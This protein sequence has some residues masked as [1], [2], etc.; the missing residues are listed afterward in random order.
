MKRKEQHAVP[1]EYADR[2][3][4]VGGLNRYGRPNFL[5]VWGQSWT[6]RRG[7]IWN[8]DDGTYFRGYRDVVEDG[9]PCWVLK[10]WKAPEIYG[11]PALWFME[12]RDAAS[13]LQILGDFPWHGNYETVQP[14]VWK[15]LVNGRLVV[16]AMPLNSMIIDMVVPI[17]MKCKDATMTQ[18]KLAFEEMEARKNRDEVR[19]IEARKHDAKMAFGGNAVSFTRQGC[20][21][22]LINQ[23]MAAIEK[24]WAQGMTQL[25]RQGLG[26][27]FTR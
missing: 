3:T 13:G 10:E 15:G 14:F 22:P 25:K 24:N 8:H 9:R 20:R 17:I 21:T 11:S 16:E 18:K 27:S 23:K 4:R 5:L 7:G 26:I 6:V 19:A 12:N 2:L 1:K